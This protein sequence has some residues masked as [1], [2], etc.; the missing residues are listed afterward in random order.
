MQVKFYETESRINDFLRFPKLLYYKEI[1]NDDFKHL[2]HLYELEDQEMINLIDYTNAKL[3]PYKKEISFYYTSNFFDEYSF[4]DLITKVHSFF[5]YKD[6]DDYLEM[7][8][9]LSANDIRN[10]IIY[11]INN[12]IQEESSLD[13]VSEI[14]KDKDAMLSFLKDLPMDAAYKWNLL[15]IIDNPLKYVNSYVDLMRKI[16]PLF[17][18][19]YTPYID[20]IKQYG[21]KLIECLEKNGPE[22]INI[23]TNNLLDSRIFKPDE[24]K[25]LVSI[26]FPYNI[27]LINNETDEYIVMGLKIEEA[28]KRISEMNEHKLNQRIQIFKTLGDK[29]RYEVLKLIAKGITSTK[30]ISTTLGVSSATIS[31]HIS[32]FLSAK[33]I[34][35]ET[36]NRKINYLVD[37]EL[38]E[39]VIN[40]LKN[41][42]N[43]PN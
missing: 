11:S 8:L 40:D 39:A 31:Y 38:L 19:I 7:L 9:N 35:L 21:K 33:V 37:Y 27:S 36:C 16:K 28:L 23:L 13:K 25:I 22:S 42:L 6:E 34:K 41:D 14:T 18:E 26:L 29:T 12:V 4:I 5:S 24:N 32:S 2:H 30:D 17:K 1:N 20:K 3:E 10:S 15:L 43:F